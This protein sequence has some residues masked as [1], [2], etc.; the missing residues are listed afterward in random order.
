MSNFSFPISAEATVASALASPAA[1][2]GDGNVCRCG[3]SGVGRAG[4]AG[5]VTY[6]VGSRTAVTRPATSSAQP[7]AAGTR[8]ARRKRRRSLMAGMAKKLDC[9]LSARDQ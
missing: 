2:Q 7:E 1:T 8:H 5:G 4:E 9:A 3:I 6:I